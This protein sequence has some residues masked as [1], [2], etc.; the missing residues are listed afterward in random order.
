MI[1]Q[2]VSDRA[3]QKT[4]LYVRSI[5]KEMLTVAQRG[6]SGGGHTEQQT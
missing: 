1:L 5:E 4:L 3:R 2:L 6:K